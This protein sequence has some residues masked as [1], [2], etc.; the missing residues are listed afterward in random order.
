MPSK[1][2]DLVIRRAARKQKELRI[3]GEGP[4]R[5]NLEMLAHELGAR[6]QFLG[7]L[8]QRQ[9]RDEYRRAVLLIHTSETGSLDKVVLEALCLRPTGPHQRPGAQADRERRPEYIREHHSL[10]R[11]VPRILRSSRQTINRIQKVL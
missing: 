9:L 10:A 1:R 7:P 3:A 4:E 2:H 5:H 6:V 11:L 8:T